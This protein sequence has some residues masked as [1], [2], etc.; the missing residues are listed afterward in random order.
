[1]DLPSTMGTAGIAG[2]IAAEE[3]AM[4]RDGADEGAGSDA[5]AAPAE[6]GPRANEAPRETADRAEKTVRHRNNR[7]VLSPS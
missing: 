4:E 6:A 7:S 1:M 3:E 2:A 5:T